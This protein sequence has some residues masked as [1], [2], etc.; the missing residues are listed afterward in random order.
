MNSSTVRIANM[1]LRLLFL[2][3]LILGVLFWLHKADQFVG[4]HMLLGLLFVVDVWFLGVMQGLRANGS[5]GLTVGT[6]IVGLLLAIIG[7][8][9]G[10][11]YLPG[12]I[13]V[14]HVLLALAAMGLGEVSAARY[15]R[16]VSTTPP[17][18]GE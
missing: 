8:V 7:L 6:F 14:L 2:I 1:V 5:I 17:A 16:S 18:T 4:L 13:Q 12:W 3:Q 11:G 15:N 10:A 9:Q